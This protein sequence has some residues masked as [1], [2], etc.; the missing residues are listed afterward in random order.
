MQYR[1]CWMIDGEEQVD[2]RL[3][4]NKIVPEMVRNYLQDM[5]PAMEVRIEELEDNEKTGNCNEEQERKP[6]RQEG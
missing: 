4:P 3:W 1:L 2:H 5:F 6:V